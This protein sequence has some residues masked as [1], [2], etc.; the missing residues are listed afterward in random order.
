MTIDSYIMT[1]LAPVGRARLLHVCGSPHAVVWW[2]VVW[3]GVTA[4]ARLAVLSRLQT[5]TCQYCGVFTAAARTTPL[6]TQSSSPARSLGT[7]NSASLPTTY[8]L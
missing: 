4:A 3:C 1:D 5:Q 8:K 2:G 6:H 7:D